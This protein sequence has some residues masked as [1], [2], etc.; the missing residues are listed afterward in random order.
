M[1]RMVGKLLL[2][3]YYHYCVHLLK[4]TLIFYTIFFRM[5]REIAKPTYGHK[6]FV[7]HAYVSTYIF[8][9]FNNTK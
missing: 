2:W 4:S 6:F 5:S 7:H 3:A 1:P 9:N 8:G